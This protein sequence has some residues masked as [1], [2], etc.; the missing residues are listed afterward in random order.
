MKKIY[1]IGVAFAMCSTIYCQSV[2]INEIHYNNVG[3]DVNEGVE[4]AGPFST[5][6]SDYSIV[7]YNGG[8]FSV[9]STTTLSGSIPNNENYRGVV[10]FDIPDIQNGAPD[11][12]ALIDP[13]GNVVQFLSYEGVITAADGPAIGLTSTNIGVSETGLETDESLQL[14]GSGTEYADFTWA[15]SAS[16]T[17]N[18]KNTGQTFTS[19]PFMVVNGSAS[20]L[21]YEL[22]L[23]PSNEGNFSVSGYNL[24]SNITINSSSNFEISLLSGSGFGASLTLNESL[25]IV[26]PTAI[27]V[28]LKASLPVAYYIENLTLSTGATSEIIAINGSVFQT[29]SLVITGIYD[30]PLFGGTP[31][32]IE[33]YVIN[34]IPDLSIYGIGVANNGGGT[35]GEE[36]TFPNISIAKDTYIYLTNNATS[37]TS[38]FGFAP[39]YTD[40]IF[41]VNGDDSVELFQNG[42]VIDAFGDINTNG[43]GEPWEYLDGWA[44][45]NTAGPNSTFVVSEWDYSSIG[46]LNGETTNATATTPFP[47]GS[48]D[49]T[50]LSVVKNEIEGFAFYPNPVV[51]GTLFLTSNSYNSKK[52]EIYD[53]TGRLIYNN[54][55]TNNE[56]INISH[57]PKGIYTA[58][59]LEEGKIATRKLVI[60]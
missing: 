11:G 19:E 43:T 12:I 20:G 13:L 49:A 9:Y 6:L 35:D 55:T 31:K 15:G 32:G 2:F 52:I 60:N 1:L 48:Y 58:R 29:N 7:L 21:N 22:G 14:T 38:F 42:A 24:T 40:I 16:A 30:G 59:I 27:Y 44:Y 28:R 3:G 18:N 50:V 36:F 57:L 4:I 41:A 25:G 46:A 45:R 37:F 8:D 26:S 23:G 5:D 51:N 34:D 54:T 56:P 53:L 17:R 47:I 33:L 10:W 39:D